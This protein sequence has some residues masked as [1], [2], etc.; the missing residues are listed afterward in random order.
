MWKPSD[1]STFNSARLSYSRELSRTPRGVCPTRPNHWGETDRAFKMLSVPKQPSMTRMS[2]A[3]AVRDAIQG[4][5][6]VH[7][8]ISCGPPW[9]TANHHDNSL[10]DRVAAVLNTDDR[11]RMRHEIAAQER[12]LQ[13][14]LGIA[15]GDNDQYESMHVHPVSSAP[16]VSTPRHVE[17]LEHEVAK[18]HVARETDA[19][20]LHL[21][22]HFTCGS[23]GLHPILNLACPPLAVGKRF[24]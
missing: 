18:R 5:K 1:P 22:E 12:T 15:D 19:Y 4:V 3:C 10:R 21:E 13:A 8:R 9:S 17:A 2:A 11:Q 14:K 23:C 6:T 16:L 24:Q 7:S 20:H